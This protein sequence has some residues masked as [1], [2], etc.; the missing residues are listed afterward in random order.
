MQ[1]QIKAVITDTEPLPVVMTVYQVAEFLQVSESAVYLWIAQ[2]GSFNPPA[3]PIPFKR[4]PGT[5]TI[6]F[7][8]AEL[9]AWLE[10]K[11]GR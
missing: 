1:E 6:R 8:K 11:E 10:R 7:I 4:L 9:L 2:A 3:D 5:R